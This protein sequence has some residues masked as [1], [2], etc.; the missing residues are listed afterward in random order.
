[1][2]ET[3][4]ILSVL[5]IACASMYLCKSDV[6]AQIASNVVSGFIGYMGKTSGLSK[7]WIQ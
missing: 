4:V 3:L 7:V 1:M 6:S 5:V 2:N